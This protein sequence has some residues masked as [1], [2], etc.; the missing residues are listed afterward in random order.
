MSSTNN[1]SIFIFLLT[2]NAGLV[3]SSGILYTFY[4]TWKAIRFP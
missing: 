2:A 1:I 4:A 3:E